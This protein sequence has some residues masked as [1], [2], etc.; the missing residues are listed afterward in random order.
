MTK[1]RQA[2]ILWA[3]AIVILLTAVYAATTR[4]G[5]DWGG[6]FAQYLNHARNLAQGRP[7][8]QSLYHATFPDAVTHMPAMYPPVFPLLLAPIY[9]HYGLDYAP[10]KVLTAGM[11]VLASLMT[12]VLARLRKLPLWLA[13]AAAL[14]FGTSGLVLQT[15]DLVLSDGTYLLFA[16]LGLTAAILVERS[17][18]DR[19]RPVWVAIIVLAP[20]LLA[21]G[22]RAIGLAL[23]VGFVLYSLAQRRYGWYEGIVVVGFVAGILIY[24]ATLYDPESYRGAVQRDLSSFLSNAK[25]YL[26]LPALLWAGSPGWLRHPLYLIGTL[27]VT[28]EWIICLFYRRTILEFYVATCLGA[29]LVYSG[30]WNARYLLPVLALYFIYLFEAVLDIGERLKSIRW[31]PAAACLVLA[32]GAV[33]N[34][35]GMDKGPYPEGI[36]QPTFTALCNYIDHNVPSGALIVSWNPR[37][38]ALYTSR[39]SVW[40]PQDSTL[41]DYLERT[42]AAYVLVYGGNPED[43]Q[44]LGPYLQNDRDF[45]SAY[46]NQDFTLYRRVAQR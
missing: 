41:S 39:R 32:T 34:V 3:L 30:G 45:T 8:A 31:I 44:V 43:T 23:L 27:T 42:H 46:R 16:G 26:R 18:W 25:S 14:A 19:S 37:V 5:Q 17:G 35:R 33:L 2:E 15:K 20:M 24:S 36:Q 4:P 22:A 11:F 1:T 7:Y 28:I 12:F 13:G 9:A 38:L 40:Y 10:M 21:Y 29:V 6:D